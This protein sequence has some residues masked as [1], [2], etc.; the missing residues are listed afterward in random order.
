VDFAVDLEERKERI[1]AED[2]ENTEFTAKN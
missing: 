2:T 1:N